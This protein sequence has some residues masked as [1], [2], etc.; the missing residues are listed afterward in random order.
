MSRFFFALVL[1]CL[2]SLF[3]SGCAFTPEKISL[4]ADHVVQK[5]NIG[6]KKRVAVQVDDLRASEDIGGRP[7]GYGPAATI[8]LAHSL[9]GVVSQSM[10]VNLKAAGFVPVKAS[11]QPAERQVVVRILNLEYKQRAGFMTGHIDLIAGAE[12][13]ATRYDRHLNRVYRV[14]KTMDILFTPSSEAD[15]K[16][17]NRAYKALIE[18]IFRDESWQRFLA[19][20]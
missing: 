17:I 15:T 4:N 14:K 5:K 6:Q 18:K 12:L 1:S 9:T 3:L 2:F 20:S 13:V 11:S 10:R 8:S 19:K 7:S 16:L